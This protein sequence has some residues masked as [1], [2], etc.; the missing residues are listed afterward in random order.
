MSDS[1]NAEKSQIAIKY[2]VTL[3]PL[4]NSGRF[5]L[6]VSKLI[7]E[8]KGTSLFKL[9]KEEYSGK[10]AIER[11]S[12]I[13]S[14]GESTIEGCIIEGFA[15][16]LELRD[17]I[18][19]REKISDEKT[20]KSL[21][22][23]LIKHDD[24]LVITHCSFLNLN[25]V[26]GLI[27]CKEASIK[28][29]LIKDVSREQGNG[30]AI[31]SE[32]ASLEIV[33]TEF[34]NCV[35][36]N[37]NGGGIYALINKNLK[38]ES[39]NNIC[40][41]LGCSAKTSEEQN[42]NEGGRGGGIFLTF[43]SFTDDFGLRNLEFGSGSRKNTAN[44]GSNL[45][46]LS[47]NIE[48]FF[49]KSLLPFLD[50]YSFDENEFC[51]SFED[52]VKNT[53]SFKSL[54]D[55]EFVLGPSKVFIDASKGND[56]NDCLSDEKSCETF[57]KCFEKIKMGR[58]NVYV[59]GIC[60]LESDPGFNKGSYYLKNYSSH[61]I[62]VTG[63][64]TIDFY[65]NTS[66]EGVSFSL[67]SSPSAS[68]SYPIVFRCS[69][70]SVIFKDDIFDSS[71][72]DNHFISKSVIYCSSGGFCLN[73]CTFKRLNASDSESDCFSSIYWSGD[74][75]SIIDCIFDDIYFEN[76]N[77]GAVTLD[78][79]KSSKVFIEGKTKQTEFK[80][81]HSNKGGGI[82]FKCS[83]IPS[84][85]CF[86]NILFGDSSCPNTASQGRNIFIESTLL[87]DFI[88][89]KNF[90]VFDTDEENNGFE[91]AFSTY[92]HLLDLALLAKSFDV[93]DVLYVGDNGEDKGSDGSN[94]CR[95]KENPCKTLDHI[96][97]SCYSGLKDI[98][99][100]N[101][102]SENDSIIFGHGVYQIEGDSSNNQFIPL[103]QCKVS[104]DSDTSFSNLSVVFTTEYFSYGYKSFIGL[105]SGVLSFYNVFLTQS[106]STTTW[107][108]NFVELKGGDMFINNCLFTNFIFS[109]KK[110]TVISGEIS[111]F[112]LNNTKFNGCSTNQGYGGALYLTLDE[113]SVLKIGSEG[114]YTSFS[115]C[116]ALRGGGVYLSFDSAECSVLLTDLSFGKEGKNEAAEMGENMLVMADDLGTVVNSDT[117]PFLV[118]L[119]EDNKYMGI[120]S[121][122]E[123]LT[124]SLIDVVNN[125]NVGSSNAFIGDKGVNYSSCLTAKSLC[126]S[127]GLGLKSSKFGS[128]N[129]KII[130]SLS[131]NEEIILIKSNCSFTGDSKNS[132]V[133]ALSQL[134]F[135]IYKDT[136]FNTLIF[137]LS[138]I[139]INTLL[140]IYK[141]T[142]TLSSVTFT[143]LTDSCSMV[144]PLI[145]ITNNGN[146]YINSCVF[147]NFVVSQKDGSA[148]K[149]KLKNG[150]LLQISKS[151]FINCEGYNSKGGCIYTQCESLGSVSLNDTSFL[152]C[153]IE[154]GDGGALYV[155]IKEKGSFT[156]NLDGQI[157]NTFKK[158]SSD[159]LDGEGGRGGAI[160][161]K[162]DDYPEIVTMNGLSFG[163]EEGDLNIADEGY[164]IFIKAN[165]LSKLITP[166]SFPFLSGDDITEEEALGEEESEDGAYLLSVPLKYVVIGVP[167]VSYVNIESKYNKKYC[168]PLSYP[169]KTLDDAFD[170]YLEKEKKVILDSEYT[171]DGDIIMNSSSYTISKSEKEFFV[172]AGSECSFIITVNSSFNTVPFIL[173]S[174]HSKSIMDVREGTLSLSSV[175]FY[176]LSGICLLS[177]S[178]ISVTLNGNSVLSS[179]FV[180]NITTNNRN[181]SAIYAS[182]SSSS[183]SIISS[184]FTN[185]G[186]KGGNGGALYVDLNKK[187]NLIIDGKNSKKTIFKGCSAYKE[188]NNLEKCN[189]DVCYGRG[190]AIYIK[191]ESNIG[192]IVM[193][194]IQFGGDKEEEKNIAYEGY[195]VFVEAEGLR[196]IINDDS[197]PFLEAVQTDYEGAYGIEEGDEEVV[198]LLELFITQTK[199]RNYW[200]VG[201]IVV[202]FI[203]LVLIIVLIIILYVKKLRKKN[204][205]KM[206]TDSAFEPL[207]SNINTEEMI[208]ERDNTSEGNAYTVGGVV[209]KNDF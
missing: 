142:L 208:T 179:C 103:S 97:S 94:L 76:G 200:W 27:T 141:G 199:K 2:D 64:N 146:A 68:S 91:G 89:L 209:F 63:I 185:C 193:D 175:S 48:T 57:E 93:A 73:G 152:A 128:V 116:S 177:S 4:K 6:L 203:L 24:E 144:N 85:I 44:S 136:E 23:C 14:E 58:K 104:V 117:F 155:N 92:G 163:K 49:S 207:S 25:T 10:L 174:S 60:Y 173:S 120:Y 135:I 54:L 145:D 3:E 12:F 86:S 168:G 197:F 19:E 43:S 50:T 33:D 131:S 75:L 151:Q 187:A 153:S 20:K 31:Y 46:I 111:T 88:Y 161:F 158:C 96:I 123:E 52:D 205:Y 72:E 70:L 154:K 105:E 162:F 194:N 156:T 37:G 147:S 139:L 26:Q 129:V 178:L 59:I 7:N 192:K 113:L 17:C 191:A 81:C 5:S 98:R 165:D 39:K 183:L 11:V 71:D 119:E 134:H 62:V 110:I 188:S 35:C 190:G 108:Y 169:C 83:F 109:G 53:Y 180:S 157:N 100:L 21:S 101:T 198:N 74:S 148:I 84:E 167:E 143:H 189:E 45:F 32:E 206:S 69:A 80:N 186:V 78:M 99:I 22:Y 65:E 87:Y 181:G 28:E 36:L 55:E 106:D 202:L 40:C 127:F 56:D 47:N 171:F 107:S 182:L 66:F 149:A 118:D 133:N 172:T 95:K 16:K 137:S 184:S 90:P 150:M 51:F 124:C 41:F 102:L 140:M 130:D 13:I 61:P 201:V 38:F 1:L 18:L 29:S 195:D 204:D 122:K 170:R 166:D 138:D 34:S 176:P 115:N 126:N 42:M 121:E 112:I 67:R 164:N 30:A 196:N 114:S 82:Y 77:G 15:G 9:V 132:I 79:K 125:L 159:K 8:E 160:Y